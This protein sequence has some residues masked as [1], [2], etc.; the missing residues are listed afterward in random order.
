MRSSLIT[1][2]FAAVG[3]VA[4]DSSSLT[5]DQATTI[6]KGVIDSLQAVGDLRVKLQQTTPVF[7]EQNAAPGYQ[8]LADS[9]TSTLNL[10]PHKNGDVDIDAPTAAQAAEVCSLVPKFAAAGAYASD[11]LVN[12]P[13]FQE[14]RGAARDAAINLGLILDNLGWNLNMF[15]WG[16]INSGA[17]DTCDKATQIAFGSV[18]LLLMDAGD[19]I[20]Y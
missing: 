4:V 1:L 3:A 19:A 6:L 16:F 18:P 11:T 5:A 10:F 2:A 17:A 20:L 9:F 8:S 7:T 13:G 14:S 15:H 12:L